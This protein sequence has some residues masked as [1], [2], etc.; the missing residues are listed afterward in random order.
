MTPGRT[1]LLS[2]LDELPRYGSRPLYLWRDGVRWRSRSYETVHRRSLACAAVLTGSGLE[3][4]ETVLLQG[5]E[6]ADWVEALHGI[7]R[8]GGVAV[9]LSPDAPE[10]FRRKAA[11]KV[12]GKFLIAPPSLTVP[13]GVRRIDLGS[14]TSVPSGEL[15]EVDRGLD[16]RAEIIFT[17]GTTG[18][19]KGVILTHGNLV[20][21][22]APIERKYRGWSPY[23]RPLGIIRILTTVPLS[24]MFGQVIAAFLVPF[25]GLTAAFTPPRPREVIEA[26]RRHG[27]FGLITV[28]R[29]LDLLAAEL[30]REIRNHWNP[31]A[32]ERRRRRFAGRSFLRQSI[33]FRSIQRCFGWRF[34]FIVSGGAALQPA[35]VTFFEELGYLV[36][37]GYGL[38][39]TAPVVTLSNPFQRG[40]HSVGRPLQ[41]QEVKVGPKGEI[42]VRG[43]N[44]SPGYIGGE[45]ETISEDGWFRTGDI[46]EVDAQGRLWIRGRLK[47]VIVTPE[48]ENVYAADVEKVFQEIGSVREAC[49][50]GLSTEGGEDVHAVLL[51]NAGADSKD[52]IRR[53]N[54]LLQAKQRIRGHTVWPDEDFPRTHTGKIRKGTV[55]EVVRALRQGIS[56]EQAIESGRG[57]LRV[58]VARVARV[59]TESIEETTLLAED[60]GLKSLD[61]VEL[62]A[63]IEE[64]F[65]LTLPEEGMEMATFGDLRC[66][67]E[68]AGRGTP[69]GPRDRLPEEHLPA[70]Q[71]GKVGDA[72]AEETQ[73]APLPGKGWKGR[74]TMPHWAAT[75]PVRWFRRALEE[76]IMYP[77]IALHTRTKV[78]GRVHLESLEPPFLIVSNHRSYMDAALIKKCLPFRLRG[79]VTTGMTTRYLRCAFG[80]VTGSFWRY[81]KECFQTFVLQLLFH[82]WPLPETAG[83]RSS[84]FYAGDLADRG[85]VLLLFPEGRHVPEGSLEPFRE[86]IG[87]FARDLRCPVL[88]VY[89]EGSATVIP[90]GARWF[91]FG[92]TRVVFGRPL[93]VPA[94][95]GGAEATR[96]VEE[97]VRALAPL[98]VLRAHPS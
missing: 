88:P 63:T 33:A 51:L 27:A 86:G 25:M 74:L 54:S 31:D 19:P 81:A 73:P 36:A 58:I 53:A 21:D 11:G 93:S 8:A 48:G 71:Q 32:F 37:Q 16:D 66:L 3:P 65:D 64:E 57:D 39:E 75:W 76:A 96:K 15:P 45:G 59:E 35:L 67:V 84:L 4:G 77:L 26:A 68:S 56:A 60:L 17:S 62:V 83:F 34:R 14:W 87:L 22:L 78:A 13:S 2:Y 9:P 18:D 92:R 85:F 20:S 43:A 52:T 1:N 82:A 40:S 47:D 6:T 61:L 97:A 90:A 5:P 70:Q 79:G 42:L 55:I 28:P 98:Q 30:R 38:T 23:I 91:R 89:L 95:V 7:F 69:S 46:G 72:E 10:D 24:H 50:V 29:L 80:E 12:D 94:D 44:V 49:V 41:G